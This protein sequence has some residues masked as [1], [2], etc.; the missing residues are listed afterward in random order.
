VV[1]FSQTTTHDFWFNLLVGTAYC[2]V[3]R[4]MYI[5]FWRKFYGATSNQG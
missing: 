3:V 5:Y 2:L 1:W 4:I